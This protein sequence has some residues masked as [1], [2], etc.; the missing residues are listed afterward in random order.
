MTKKQIVVWLFVLAGL[1]AV[2]T[3]VHLTSPAY[4]EYKNNLEFVRS[5]CHSLSNALLCFN[6]VIMTNLITDLS[7]NFDASAKV[8]ADS[9]LGARMR[10][11]Q[12][13]SDAH[14]PD[15][16][17]REKITLPT[18][19]HA[20]QCQDK[21]YAIVRGWRYSIGDNFGGSPITDISPLGF[22]TLERDYVFPQTQN[23][24]VIL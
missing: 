22:S 15:A 10:A 19:C 12:G 8:A 2:N 16:S 4:R 3:V 23:K 9:P 13:E 24:E 14:I 20:S 5:E 7:R 17:K 1:L 11:G 6:A 21:L 18:G